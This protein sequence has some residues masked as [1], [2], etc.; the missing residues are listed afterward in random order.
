MSCTLFLFL[1][2]FR[3]SNKPGVYLMSPFGDQPHSNSAG[4]W[5]TALL[6]GK[7]TLQ[8]TTIV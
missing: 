7:D 6:V 3:V 5:A 2:A 4:A 8:V 1:P